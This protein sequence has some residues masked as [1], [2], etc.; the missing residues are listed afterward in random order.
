MAPAEIE[1]T[2]QR[3]VIDR[4]ID[5]EPTNTS[6]AGVT[7]A[8]SVREAKRALRRDLE[9][10]LNTRRTIEPAPETLPELRRSLHRYGLPDITSAAASST[11][12]RNWL[13]RQVE[14]TIALFE[15]RLTHVRVTIT[16]SDEPGRREV[17][18]VVEAVLEMEPSPEQVVFDT[19]LEVS[20]STFAV[21]GGADA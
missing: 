8:Q 20:S 21:E 12:A 10:L 17:R 13:R 19:V 2:A 16:D 6:D 4:L 5:T 11:D 3:S 15:P 18:F 1:R 9:W 7:L 14:E